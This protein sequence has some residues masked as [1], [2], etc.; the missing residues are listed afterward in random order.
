MTLRDKFF[1]LLF[2]VLFLS[3]FSKGYGQ[4]LKLS[5][6]GV[7]RYTDTSSLLILKPELAFRGKYEICTGGD[8]RFSIRNSRVGASG[9]VNNYISYKF[10]L[11]LSSEGKFSILD[12]YSKFNFNKRFSL[13]FGQSSLPLF[14]S[15]T[16]SPAQL[17][18]ANRPFLAKYFNSSRD[19]GFNLVYKIKSS[20]YPITIEGGLFNGDGINNPQWTNS[21]AYSA[22]LTFGELAQG[23]KS[24]AK[25]YKTRR[26]NTENYLMAGADVRYKCSSFKV[27]AEAMTKYNLY[28][29]DYLSSAYI[30]ALYVLPLKSVAFSAVEPLFRWDAMGYDLLDSGFGVN[31][32]TTGANLRIRLKN[33]SSLVRV[34]YEHYFNSKEL[35]EFENEQMNG[36]KFTIE[37]V[38]SF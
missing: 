19:I 17:D 26:S 10:I 29:D 13:T 5:N 7:V 37:F 28:N 35:P 36:S 22:R 38:L 18:Y 24:S 4:E 11:E 14:N 31:R 15:Y 30:Q 25:F 20:G 8:Y 2:I 6:K 3:L 27:E 32:V 1:K 23:F 33:Y 16:T 21:M 12:L 34:N 9:N